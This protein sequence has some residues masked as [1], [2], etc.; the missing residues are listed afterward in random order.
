MYPLTL[1]RVSEQT[2]TGIMPLYKVNVL[3]AVVS[4]AVS[5]GSTFLW[6][7]TRTETMEVIIN[8]IASCQN[9]L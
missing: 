2:I 1:H 7:H 8:R 5:L 3:G 9:Y 6:P 4:S